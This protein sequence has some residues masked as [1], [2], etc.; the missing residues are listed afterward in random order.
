M[1]R[2]KVYVTAVLL[3]ITSMGLSFLIFLLRSKYNYISFFDPIYHLFLFGPTIAALIFL[4][5]S[6][7]NILQ[8]V[9]LNKIRNI[10]AV[11]IAFILLFVAAILSTLIQYYFGFIRPENN[12]AFFRLF[13][14]QFSPVSGS[15][16]WL[17]LLL[18]HAGFAEE[19]AWRGYLY[20][21]LKHLPWTEQVLLINTI[22]AIWHFPFMRFSHAEQYILFWVQCLELGTVLV[23]ARFRTGSSISAMILHPLTV[24]SL[25]VLSSP[26]FS[27]VNSDWAGWPNYTIAILFLPIAFYYFVRGKH[28]TKAISAA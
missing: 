2:V 3:L 1:K 7:D 6:R 28:E 19:F 11:V 17:F 27:V 16:I 22:W 14:I 12:E 23:Y 20:S 24:F 5:I 18:V 13:G 10:S 25:S 26:Y 9:G 15:L 4:A 8:T 21:R